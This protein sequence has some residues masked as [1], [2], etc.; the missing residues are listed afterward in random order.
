MGS[1]NSKDD[2][3]S[4]MK[5]VFTNIE[6]K[7]SIVGIEDKLDWHIIRT[8]LYSIPVGMLT[9]ITRTSHY[10]LVFDIIKEGET[11]Y[12]IT[13]FTEDGIKH[14]K[15]Y[16]SRSQAIFA[17]FDGTYLTS[18]IELLSYRDVEGKKVEDLVRIFNEWNRPFNLIRNNCRKYT[19]FV[20][21]R[22]W[23]HASYV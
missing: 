1:A 2:K 9:H 23:N 4:L 5:I 17:P 14:L 13:H 16:G 18:K 15:F 21:R 8:S 11:G 3:P 19:K 10:F 7:A 6:N 20:H 12:I 22:L